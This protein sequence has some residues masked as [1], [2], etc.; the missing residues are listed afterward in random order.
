MNFPPPPIQT[1]ADRLAA[2]RQQEAAEKAR[3]KAAEDAERAE[4]GRLMETLTPQQVIH[5]VA[6]IQRLNF[7]AP[8][9]A[10]ALL[11]E[12]QQLALALHHAEFLAGM[13]D[14][15]PLPTEPEVRE[16]ARSVR[17]KV[18]GG[19]TAPAAPHPSLLPLT[20]GPAGVVQPGMLA[21]PGMVG[22]PQAAPVVD[23]TMGAPFGTAVPAFGGCVP[24]PPPPMVVP[25]S[26]T[27]GFMQVPGAPQLIPQMMTPPA[28]GVVAAPPPPPAAVPPQIISQVLGVAASDGE[29]CTGVMDHLLTLS[30][31]EIDKLP[32]NTKVQL[33]EFLQKMPPRA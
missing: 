33:L 12:N 1:I 31:A 5:I 23:L 8:E 29:A 20:Q 7:R 30:P 16:R 24:A 19:P 14:D 13:I 32:H 21:L 25:V 11:A 3:V 6:E 28:L 15:P 17:E 27:A 2:Q 26:P 4:V 22:M 10:R 9:V 18:W